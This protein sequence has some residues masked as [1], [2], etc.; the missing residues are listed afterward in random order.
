MFL[1]LLLLLIITEEFSSILNM[2]T[3]FLFI[4][5]ANGHLSTTTTC[6]SPPPPPPP[7]PHRPK[8]AVVEPLQLEKTQIKPL[9]CFLDHLGKQALVAI[10]K[11]MREFHK[12]S[13]VKFVPRINE[14]DY[15]EFEGNLG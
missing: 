14:Q 15:I 7:P 11:A 6:R 5:S 13:C 9:T 2:N 8:V 1:L 4:T 3:E 10:R 12:R